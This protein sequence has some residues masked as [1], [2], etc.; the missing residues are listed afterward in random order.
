MSQ[1][2]PKAT[3]TFDELP[4]DPTGPLGNAW[5][6][7]G[8]DDSLGMLNLLNQK[9]TTVAA[10]EIQAGKRISLDLPLNTPFYPSYGRAAFKH[11][12]FNRKKDNKP[13]VVNDELVTFN[14]QGSSQW[15][16]FRHFGQWY[17]CLCSL[18]V[19]T[20]NTRQPETLEIL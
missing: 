11:E 3:L 12:I 16:G 14:T 13:R 9:T 6:R 4:L 10:K 15:D 5:G 2:P 17:C 18:L 8:P 7:F 1:P 20:C 19:L